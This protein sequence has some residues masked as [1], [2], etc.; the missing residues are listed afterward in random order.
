MSKNDDLSF[1][2]RKGRQLCPT[3]AEKG[4]N[5]EKKSMKQK[6]GPKI[7]NQVNQK[8]FFRK[9]SIILIFCQFKWSLLFL[10]FVA[11]LLSSFFLPSEV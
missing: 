5:K 10:E 2:C 4:I 9:I 7:K 3:K 11:F 1:H 6:I 8:L